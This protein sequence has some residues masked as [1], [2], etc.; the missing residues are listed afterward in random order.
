[1]QLFASTRLSP[2]IIAVALLTAIAATALSPAP[3]AAQ[4]GRTPEAEQ[5]CTPDVMR[6]CSDFIPN[7]QPIVRCLKRKRPQLSPQCRRFIKR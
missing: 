6:L 3:A 1:V 4:A 7:V 5:A 2:F